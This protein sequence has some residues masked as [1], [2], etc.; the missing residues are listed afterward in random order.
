MGWTCALLVGWSYLH[1]KP[2]LHL[3]QSFTQGSL[4]KYHQA[5]RA[6]CW[7]INIMAFSMSKSDDFYYIQCIVV[8]LWWRLRRGF[9][10]PLTL[11]R[12]QGEHHQQYHCRLPLQG[13]Q[14]LCSSV[15]TQLTSWISVWGVE[16]RKYLL[17]SVKFQPDMRVFLTIPDVNGAVKYFLLVISTT[18]LF[19]FIPSIFS[20]TIID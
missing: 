12:Y 7:E 19:E 4:S 6:L 13:H 10:T 17:T 1:I 18:F 2:L 20:F 8:M 11:Y 14:F 15:Q 16:R 5:A 9:V 3:T